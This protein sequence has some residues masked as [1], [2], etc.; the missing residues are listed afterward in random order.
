MVKNGADKA[1]KV[2]D[3]ARSLGIDSILLGQS[4]LNFIMH[5]L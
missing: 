4:V 1:Q 3:L 5:Q 2:E